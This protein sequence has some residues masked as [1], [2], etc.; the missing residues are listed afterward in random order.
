M[1][2]NKKRIIPTIIYLNANEPGQQKY[3][4]PG[5]DLVCVVDTGVSMKGKKTGNVQRNIVFDIRCIG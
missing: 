3:T 1:R 5:V 4:R 2:K